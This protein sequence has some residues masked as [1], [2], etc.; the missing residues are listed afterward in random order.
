MEEFD[1]DLDPNDA[2]IQGCEITGT[3]AS[4]FSITAPGGF[5]AE[6]G[7]GATVNVTV[8]GTDDQ[9]KESYSANLRCVYSDSSD[10]CGVEEGDTPAGRPELCGT[11]VNYPLVIEVGGDAYFHVLKEF[12]DGNPGKVTVDLDCDTGLILDQEKVI[13][14]DGIG[15]T[16]VVSSFDA[17]ELNCN[18]TE[19]PVAGYSADYEAGGDSANTDADDGE[20]NP[21]CYWTAVDG[22][23][24][25]S[26]V[27]TNSPDDVNVVITKEWLYPGNADASIVSDEFFLELVCYNASIDGGNKCLLGAESGQG[28]G[29]DTYSCKTLSGFGNKVFNVAVNPHTY[30]GGSCYVTEVDVDQSVEVDNG[31]IGSG[32][33]IFKLK[34]SAGSGDSCTITNTVFF[35]GIPTLSQYGM[36][37][38]ALLMLGMGFVAVRRIS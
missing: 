32:Q 22:G 31:C 11:E 29:G 37:L 24:N 33:G 12:T 9:A 17:G 27:I 20:A 21:G 6:I 36:A 5:P 26:C 10:E 18:V 25:N 30:P 16:F 34:V 7:S 2:F 28:G 8:Q 35:E 38:L 3:D 14:D 15:V 23:D 19:R 4:S 13:S 1:E